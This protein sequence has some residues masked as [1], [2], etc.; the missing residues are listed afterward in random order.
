MQVLDYRYTIF[1]MMTSG[2]DVLYNFA[3]DDT[4]KKVEIIRIGK[5]ANA[6]IATKETFQQYQYAE[7]E[8]GEQI[9]RN[10]VAKMQAYVNQY[11]K[12]ADSLSTGV[13]VY[14]EYRGTGKMTPNNCQVQVRYFAFLQDSSIFDQTDTT[15]IPL[16][17]TIGNGKL[18]RGLEQGIKEMR[19]GGVAYIFIPYHMAYGET[20]YKDKIPPRTNLMY[21]LELVSVKEEE[22]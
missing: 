4:I 20:G 13:R 7:F 12:G 1:G 5:E 3:Q 16:T 11:Y 8:K 6:F 22:N 15:G 10:I 19:E 9:K 18:T 17:T 2:F 21:R 14:H